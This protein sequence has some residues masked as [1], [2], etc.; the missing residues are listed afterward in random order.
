MTDDLRIGVIGLGLRGNLAAVAHSP[1]AGS[2]V[3]AVADTDPAVLATGADRFPG[4]PPS[5][6]IAAARRDGIDAVIVLTPTTPT[7]NR[8]R[9]PG[10]GQGRYLEKPCHHR[11]GL[12]PILRTAYE[13]GAGSTSGTTCGT[14]AVVRLMRDIIPRGDI[15]EPKTVW[16]RHFVSYGGDYYFKDW[17]ADR[18]RTTG[19]LLQKAAHDLDVIHWLA[20]GYTRA[21]T[22]WATSCCTAICRAA[23]RA[24]R[25]RRAGCGSTSGR[26]PRASDLHHVVDVED[27]SVMNMRLDNGVIAAYQQCHFSPRLLRN[28]T[29]IGT[30]GRLE[31]FGDGPGTGQGLEHRSDAATA[32]TPTRSTGCP[33]RPAATGAP[34]SGS[35]RSSAASPA[36]AGPRTPRRWPPG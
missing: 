10:G 17:H 11:R 15:G 1:G 33:T 19:L 16:V 32:R 31:N 3:A 22:P 24:P 26:R 28:Y 36:T 4:A 20:G 12:R 35:W 23:S 8:L 2:V 29:V 27:V 18:T 7:R 30:E 14:W 9:L 21:S 5:P 13:T 34:T 6:A 25:G